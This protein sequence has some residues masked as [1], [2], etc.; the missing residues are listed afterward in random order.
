MPDTCFDPLYI[1]FREE[2]Y[3]SVMYKIRIR[4]KLS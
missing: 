1:I 4:I 2:P 3:Q